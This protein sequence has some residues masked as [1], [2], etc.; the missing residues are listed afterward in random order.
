[1]A[2]PIVQRMIINLLLK[3]QP[4]LQLLKLALPSHLKEHSLVRFISQNRLL[5]KDVDVLD[6]TCEVSNYDAYLMN[7]KPVV[8]IMV[9]T[10]KEI[11]DTTSIETNKII[12]DNPQLKKRTRAN[13]LNNYYNLIDA[14]VQ[15]ST[16]VKNAWLLTHE[17][18]RLKDK[19]DCI[20]VLNM[21]NDQ[22]IPWLRLT[23]EELTNFVLYTQND[24][25][26]Y[27]Y[28]KI[29]HLAHRLECSIEKLCELTVRYTFLLKIPISYIDKKLNILHEYDVSN[30]HILKDLWVLRYSENHIRH[31]CELY[32]DTG[33]LEVKTWAIRCPLR[34]IA[35]AIQKNSLKRGLM[36][37]HTSINEYLMNKLKIDEER[38]NLA[39]TKS[40]GILRVNLL[41]LNR[42]ISI[43]HQ[44]GITSDEILRHIRIFYFNVETVQ[45]R[46]KIMKK[47]CLV[48]KLA[49]LAVAEQSFERHIKNRHLQREILQ[50]YQDV[51]EY[52][53]N[54]LNVDEE[55]LEKALTRWPTILRVNVRK[56]NQ[57]I[58]LLQQNG[59]M[60][61][62][63]LRHPRVFYFNTETLRKR[64]E[65]LKEAGLPPKVSLIMY[66][67]KN[68]DEY[69]KYKLQK[70]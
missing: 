66:S 68:L 14:G 42:L 31:R 56:I 36:R 57:L 25:G 55:L 58:D 47:E 7:Y 70:L 11:L 20:K 61:D 32:K 17:N 26:P 40:P 51:K 3:P 28:N 50:D 39:I 63:I 53:I 27:T 34:V 23:Q 52:L 4:Q 24:M 16:I 15:K 62:E 44:N 54:K 6:H 41:K 12:A 46:I 30:K 45:N 35:R 65:M 13:I 64:I 43:L 2:R 5:H 49:V 60:G 9:Q 22:L 10:L 59:I 1:M 19:L 37:H 8:R 29:E 48:P 67:Q 69:V 33:N 21:N 18:N 38:L